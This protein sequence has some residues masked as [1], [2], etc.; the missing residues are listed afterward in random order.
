MGVL[1]NIVCY[2]VLI[3][4]SL[5]ECLWLLDLKSTYVTK[6]VS[7]QDFGLEPAKVVYAHTIL[8]SRN[9]DKNIL[10]F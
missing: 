10:P 8:F 1:G 9:R 2:C 7:A 5:I 4:L 3:Y 6:S